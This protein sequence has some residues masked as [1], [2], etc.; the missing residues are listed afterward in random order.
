MRADRNV[1]INT[2]VGIIHTSFTLTDEEQYLTITILSKMFKAVNVPDRSQPKQLPAAIALEVNTG[3]YSRQTV[4]SSEYSQTRSARKLQQGDLVAS[5]ESWRQALLNMILSAYPDITPDEKLF[6][7]KI[8]NDLL[9]GL[10]LPMRAALYFP[11]D[12]VRAYQDLG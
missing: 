11:E 6:I 8:L 1:W 2:F 4:A 9:V 10:G 12:V 5:V 7:S 3:F